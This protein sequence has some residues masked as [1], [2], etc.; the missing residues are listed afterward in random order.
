MY[1]RWMCTQWCNYRCSYCPQNHTR[2]Q[3]YKGSPG[4]WADN[5]PWQEWYDAFTRHFAAYDTTLHLT[6]GEPMLDRKNML[7]LLAVLSRQ[8]W[9]KF[10]ELDTNGTFDP[11]WDV[12]RSRFG[13][14]LS[15]HP[16]MV[17]ESDYFTKVDRLQSH[18]WPIMMAAFVVLPGGFQTM[19]RFAAELKSRGIPINVMTLDG[20]TSHYT[21]EQI[22][23]LRSY[24][25]AADW[26]H[27]EASPRGKQCTYSSVSYEVDP[28]GS[29]IVSCHRTKGERYHGSLWSTLPLRPEG[30]IA[31]PKSSCSCEERYTHLVE[32]GGVGVSPKATVAARLRS[33]QLCI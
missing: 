9:V 23:E 18:G 6:G 26:Y 4:H 33:L 5:Q 12:D 7:P 21:P 2:K 27:A 22:E 8:P 10:L 25:P 16:E 15:Y 24:V 30:A 29:V 3:V 28:D 31:C 19:R 1:V 14:H 13:L 20:R 11:D 17:S 32:L